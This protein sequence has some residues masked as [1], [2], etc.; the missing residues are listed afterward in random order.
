METK[1]VQ[2]SGRGN[3]TIPAKMRERY[4]LEEGDPLSLVDLGGVIVLV[5]KVG[6]AGKLAGEIERLS[7]RAGIAVE[8]LVA[9]VSEERA[10]YYTERVAKPR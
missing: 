10:A 5:P 7:R 1:I 8:E 3:V 9:G 4:G 6:V 2:V